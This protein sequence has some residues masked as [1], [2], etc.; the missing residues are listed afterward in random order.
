[1]PTDTKALASDVIEDVRKACQQSGRP[2]TE[3]EVR[4]TLETLDPKQVDAVRRLARSGLTAP[5]GPDALVDVTQGTPVH[6]ASAREIG[7]YY[8]MKAERDALATIAAS[9]RSAIAHA[10]E[11]DVSLVEDDYDDEESFS[12][13][14]DDESDTSDFDDEE[15]DFDSRSF[16]DEEDDDVDEAD[17]YEPDEYEPD[18]DIDEADEYEPDEALVAPEA[19]KKRPKRRS[20]L[21]PEEREQEQIITT[22]FAYHR[23]AVRV[24]QELGI[25]L[26][27]LSD[28]ID[29]L[30]LRR[31]IH[32]LLEQT[33]DID[34]FLPSKVES[35]SPEPVVRKR[36]QKSKTARPADDPEREESSYESPSPAAQTDPVNAH[37]T[38]VYRRSP[39][40]VPARV[41]ASELVLRREYVREPKRRTRAS[42][43]KPAKR[44]TSPATPPPPQAPPRLPFMD[45][46]AS[47]GRAILDKLL[48]DEKANPRLLARKLAERFDGPAGR[49]VNESDLRSLLQAHGLAERF[50]DLETANT[51]FMIGFHQGARS[52]LSN[53]LQM[54]P[55][56]LD[57]YLS[58]LDLSDELARIRAERS[59][60]ELGRRKLHDRISQV[61]TRAPYLD[62]LGVL[63]VVDREVREQLEDLFEACGGDAE[64]VR[65]ELRLEPNPFAKLLRRYDV[66]EWQAGS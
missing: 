9:G 55:R 54:T 62:D 31:R 45:L 50:A 38:R 4:R 53:A 2:T 34:M 47:G 63:P 25:G 30:N 16:H 61:L 51:R 19:V 41:P 29:E 14:W 24:A 3:A 58:K 1:M 7:G 17:E 52:K 42:L 26:Q 18:D 36:G 56:E 5:L 37:G 33:T 49:D 27:E 32:R 22:L 21:T 10:T 60:L 57:A 6:M 65:A 35:S 66:P 46:Q 64:K 39:D 13:S 15:G 8:T 48:A 12:T 20:A 28:R 43:P 40:S 59:K 11:A 23:D 44:P